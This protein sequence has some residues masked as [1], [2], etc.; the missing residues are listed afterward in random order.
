M[1][2]RIAL[3]MILGC[4]FITVGTVWGSSKAEP[5]KTVEATEISKEM[6][7][8]PVYAQKFA[9]SQGEIYSLSA[10]SLDGYTDDS[11]GSKVATSDK[12]MLEG[13]YF[14]NSYLA[15]FLSTDNKGILN[16]YCEV[17]EAHNIYVYDLY[18]YKGKSVSYE[19]KDEREQK[20]L[21]IVRARYLDTEVDTDTSLIDGS[22]K[23]SVLSGNVKFDSVEI[24]DLQWGKLALT[25]TTYSRALVEFKGQLNGE[26]TNNY[27]LIKFNSNQQ[28]KEILL[29]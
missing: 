6:A 8:L 13:V 23:D 29:V 1:K 12:N 3:I 2:K 10:V 21:D 5:V 27:V 17:T 16:V 9:N 18:G 19:V 20:I 28:I 24:T 26:V 22:C 25:D 11:S 7:T 15:R 4:L 14:E